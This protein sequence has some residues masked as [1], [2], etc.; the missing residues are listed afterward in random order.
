MKSH[1]ERNLVSQIPCPSCEGDHWID[2][3]EEDGK[4]YT[5]CFGVDIEAYQLTEREL[6]YW[7]I[8]DKDILKNLTTNVSY[9]EY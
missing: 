1:W 8:P 3:Y 7:N 9:E 4:Y 2:V 5:L 6:K